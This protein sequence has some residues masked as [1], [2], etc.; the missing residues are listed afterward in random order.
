MSSPGRRRGLLLLALAAAAAGAFLLGSRACRAPREVPRTIVLVTIDTL[1]RDAVG[2]YQGLAEAAPSPTPRLDSLARQGLTFLDART[3][4]PLTL[5]AHVTLLSGLSPAV[6]GVRLNAF[7]RL[8]SGGERGFPLLPEAFRAAGWRTGAFV[9]A[10]PLAALHGLDQGFE[11]YDDGPFSPPGPGEVPQRS[12]PETVGRAL[13]WLRTAGPDARVLLWVHLFEPHAPYAAA[14]SRR[15]G[16]LADVRSADDA[17]GALLDGLAAQ[18][19]ADAALLVVSDHGEMLDELGEATHGHLLGDAVLRVPFVLRA[20]GLA[21]GLRSDPVELADAAPTLAAL[22]GLPFSPAG[23]TALDLL[24]APAPAARVRVAETL[25]AHHR[26][27]WAQLV[28]ATGP[29]GTLVDAGRDRAGWLTPAPPGQ[30]QTALTRVTSA[31]PALVEALGRYKAGEQP[32]RMAPGASSGGYGSAG[33]IEPFLSPEANGAL[34]DPY[35]AI[36]GVPFLDQARIALRTLVAD[37]RPGALRT[38][39][40][41]L[42]RMRTED[43]TNPELLFVAGL[44]AE[45]RASEA[46]AAGRA[47]EVEPALAEA[48]RAYRQAF[49]AGRRDAETLTRLCGVRAR[50]RE[51]EMLARLNE[52]GRGIPRSALLWKLI[53]CLHE[54]L[55]Q[56]PEARAA[57]QQAAALARTPAERRTLEAPCR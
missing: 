52:L 19:R 24:A 57:A 33:S 30:P 1:R 35:L 54:A 6:S 4:V 37:P 50:G 21:A 15:A 49:D 39:A 8:G 9:S 18:G 34:R 46:D 20:P 7:G 40:P 32:G 28:A 41:R 31:E 25:Y 43:P 48:E 36:H 51:A 44:V 5:P 55:G 11:A 12:G 42:E 2:A 38:L 23:S 3:P 22:A 53:S 27:R 26:F 13:S 56:A 14:P 29:A 45:A 10:E 47:D 17:L 16:Y